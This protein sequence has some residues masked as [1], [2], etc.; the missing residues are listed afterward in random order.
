VKKTGAKT[1]ILALATFPWKRNRLLF[2]DHCWSLIVQDMTCTSGATMWAPGA[3]TFI[4]PEC[5]AKFPPGLF[6]LR[7][8]TKECTYF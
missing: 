1:R 5:Y 7:F 8:R 4:F 3:H 2:V 6:P